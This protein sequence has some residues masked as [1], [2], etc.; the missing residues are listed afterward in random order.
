MLQRLDLARAATSALEPKTFEAFGAGMATILAFHL[1]LSHTREVTR[2]APWVDSVP[3]DPDALED[4]H[5]RA[6]RFRDAF[7]HFGEKAERDFDFGPAAAEP[8]GPFDFRR[9]GMRGAV[10][11]SFGFEHGEALLYAPIDRDTTTGGWARLSWADMEHAARAI[12][13]W[14]LDLLERWAEVQQR[15]AP[16]V[17]AHGHQLGSAR[18]S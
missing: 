10:V 15:W 11:V 13:A 3:L 16:F 5:R 18:P 7:M 8:P 6:A 14:T 17:E 4:L 12:E 9:P 2:R 1:V